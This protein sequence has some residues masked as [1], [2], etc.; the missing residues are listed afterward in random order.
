MDF[1]EVKEGKMFCGES[2]FILRGFGLGG[3]LLPEGYMWKLY[4]K[5]D[6][7]R[8]MEAMIS[9]LCGED[10][11]KSFWERYFR[12][13]I[14]EKDITLLANRGYNSVRLPLNARH[15]YKP[16]DKG[17]EFKNETIGILDHLIK[18]C[19]K[20]NIYVILDMHGAPGGQTGQ[21]IDDSESDV[22][23][24]FVEDRHQSDLIELWGM[25]AKRY[26]DEPAV[27]GY[28]LLNEPLPNWFSQYNPRLM[29]LY[30]KL[31][32]KIRSIDQRHPIILE[33]LHWATDFSLFDSLTKEEAQNGIILEFHKYWSHPDK[34]SLQP[35]IKMAEKLEVPLFMGEGGENNC[36]WYTTVFPLYERMGIG[37]SFWS[38][39]KMDCTNSPI[40]FDRP[41]NW[42]KILE[43]T[44]GNAEIEKKE[45]M[46]IFDELLANI[47]D[48][49]IN[50]P[51]FRALE[52]KLPLLLPAEAYDDYAGSGVREEGAH[53]RL[54]ENITILFENGKTGTV[55]YKRYGGEPQ[56]PEENLIVKLKQS[57][58]LYYSFC[59]SLEV[60]EK[61]VTIE[62][63]A[64][65]NGNL[66]CSID[67]GEPE[68][69]EINQKGSYKLC[70]IAPG[71]SNT[72]YTLGLKCTCGEILLDTIYLYEGDEHED[73]SDMF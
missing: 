62:I 24:L 34:E 18:L 56:P 25:I 22:P 53:I 1:L 4:K 51:V 27:G 72:A 73:F 49:K 41:A 67:C 68:E 13:Y 35:Y 59:S 71:D 8:R 28:D 30:R 10:Y 15:L 63:S 12:T 17:L 39:K 31:I 37:W 43:W 66:Q 14:T 29:P 9:T 65:G 32:S 42:D 48:S 45:A 38:Y 16:T 11:A 54:S 57:D 52:R 64:N 44:D 40:T 2:P 23:E 33:G 19:R 55:D 3:W 6:R 7:P 20:N 61:R 36:Q 50:T 46:E 70:L 60:G 5:C 26:K 47:S 58:E 21:N 69:I